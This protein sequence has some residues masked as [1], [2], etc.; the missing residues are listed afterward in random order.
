M[1]SAVFFLSCRNASAIAL[2]AKLRILL[3]RIGGKK[4][5]NIISLLSV[6][7]LFAA[8]PLSVL[9]EHH[10]KQPELDDVWMVLPKK[11][12]EAEFSE[13]VKAH[14]EW[15]ERQGESRGW[16]AYTV[17][18]GDNPNIYM[19]RA[20]L[21]DWPEMDGFVKED[22]E[23]GFGKH[24]NDN[25]HQYVDHYHHY[26]ERMD[27]EH[28]NWPED[29]NDFKYYGVTTW[30]W[31]EDAGSESSEARKTISK[32]LLDEGWGEQGN[33]WLWH[34]RIG[35]KPELKIVSGF[36]NFAD[37]ARPEVSLYEFLSEH[38]GSGEEVQAMFD[39][40]NSGFASS[41]YT[42]WAHNEELSTTN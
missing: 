4:M 3:K 35:G 31:K 13:A 24:W 23:K 34:S 7:I 37:M 15:R 8:T 11:G 42:V 21:F 19:F 12:M 9:A 32:I 40:F 28:S 17:V 20:G 6:L 2:R 41:D 1:Q 10:E 26:F 27:F 22:G 25:V 36:E 16:D 38:M 29:E 14:M 39:A 33:N 5:K 30:V 18:L